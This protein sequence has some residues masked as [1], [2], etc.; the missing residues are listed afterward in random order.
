MEER[1]QQELERLTKEGEEREEKVKVEGEDLVSKILA[2]NGRDRKK[3]EEE[4]HK[5]QGRALR[6]NQQLQAAKNNLPS[7]TPLLHSLPLSS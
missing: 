7:T 5:W 1:H 4:K 6:Y 3:V 2:E